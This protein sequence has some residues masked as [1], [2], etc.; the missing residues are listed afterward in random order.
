M[1]L[2]LRTINLSLDYGFFWPL[3]VFLLSIFISYLCYPVI[4]KVSKI[5]R[6]MAKPNHRSVHKVKT[7]NLGG[8]GIFLAI[9]LIITFLGSY[10][11][12]ANLLYLLGATCIM[13][14]TGLVDDLIDTKAK[15]K[16]FIQA[17]TTLA[18]VLLTNLR[19]LDFHGLLALNELPYIVSVIITVF[20]YILI[21]NS[22]NLID[23]VDGLAGGFAI[24]VSSFFGIFYFF[25]GNDSMFFLS[26]C[27][28]GALIS[29]LIFNFS[30]KQKI[31]M[32]DTG[33]LV[34]G[35]LL[36]YQAIGFLNVDFNPNFLIQNTKAPVFV[37]A[38]FSFPLIDTAR[39][40]LL[41]IMKKKSPF[42]ADKNHIHHVFLDFGLKHWKISILASFFTLFIVSS[43]FM[44]NELEINKQTMFLFGLWTTSVVIIHS[45]KLINKKQKKKKKA[46]KLALVSSGDK[47]TKLKTIL[48]K[49]MA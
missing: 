12:D 17:G 36:A 23:G 38:L 2:S 43:V 11:E 33:S 22:Y 5:K 13:F 15:H 30:R 16:L 49:D 1:I 10:F 8:I 41:R 25:N 42:T 20:V 40:F 18:V 3:I 39:V 45:M 9:N 4:I 14:F 47:E 29:F 24:T 32:G 46:K 35:F 26:I 6:L 21:I 7:S 28:V 37:L 34:V 44:Y 27:I 48:F 31:F 19:I